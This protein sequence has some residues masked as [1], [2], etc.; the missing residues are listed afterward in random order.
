MQLCN[1]KL[2]GWGLVITVAQST[3]SS[4]TELLGPELSPFQKAHIVNW[5]NQLM[6]PHSSTNVSSV[7]FSSVQ[8]SYSAMPDSLRPNRLQHISLPCPSLTPRAYSNSCPLTHWS[9]LTISAYVIPFSNLQAFPASGSFP[10]SQFFASGGQSIVTSASYLPLLI[11]FSL[12]TFIFL[13]VVF[14]A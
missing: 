1:F 2:L 10:V 3:F 5:L 9:H 7:Q 4:R 13:V 8:F 14:S 11:I 12:V 6:L